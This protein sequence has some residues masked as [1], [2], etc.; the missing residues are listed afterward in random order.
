MMREHVEGSKEDLRQKFLSLRQTYKSDE[1]ILRSVALSK[2]I[3]NFLQNKKFESVFSF[4]SFRNEPDLTSFADK[5]CG[6]NVSYPV[7][8]DK[9]GEM[10]FYQWFAGEELT[11]N[12][13]GIDEPAVFDHSVPSIP[14]NKTLILVPALSLDLFGCRLGY[15][16]GYYDRFLQAY[17]ESCCLGICFS[18]EIS[19]DIPTDSWDRRLDYIATEKKIKKRED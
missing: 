3:E 19:P 6:L 16:G 8:S 14:D 4:F 18:N 12:K 2:Q 11:K 10:E 15:G 5:A 13:W 1:L 17:P 7:I 9:D